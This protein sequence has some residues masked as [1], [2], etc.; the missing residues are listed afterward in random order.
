MMSVGAAVSGEWAILS[1]ESPKEVCQQPV[2]GL[3]MEDGCGE[4]WRIQ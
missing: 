3:Y 2:V 4:H 1:T